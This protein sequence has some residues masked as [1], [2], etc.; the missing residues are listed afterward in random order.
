MLFSVPSRIP[1]LTPL[2]EWSINVRYTFLGVIERRLI[3]STN[4]HKVCSS[5]KIAVFF[6]GF[7]SSDDT[8]RTALCQILFMSVL[9]VS[10][11]FLLNHLFLCVACEFSLSRLHLR[12]I[13]KVHT[14]SASMCRCIYLSLQ[15][16]EMIHTSLEQQRYEMLSSF[17]EVFFIRCGPNGKSR[18]TSHFYQQKSKAHTPPTQFNFHA[19]F[20]I[21]AGSSRRGSCSFAAF[22][23]FD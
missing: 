10:N 23:L 4:V 12:L 9:R 2:F 8:Q 21:K 7:W 3:A 13:Q 18:C 17:A 11:C 16:K 1:P 19:H 20:L 14:T 5:G 6:E 22:L 15:A